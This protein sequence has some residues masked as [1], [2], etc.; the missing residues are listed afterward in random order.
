[1]KPQVVF[2]QVRPKGQRLVAQLGDGFVVPEAD[3]GWQVV[4]RPKRKAFTTWD[5]HAPVTMTIPIL[6]DGFRENRSVEQDINT[7]YGMMRK[8]NQ[9]VDEPPVVRLSGPIPYSRFQ[10]VITSISPGEEIRRKKDGRRVRSFM[11]VTVLEYV[12]ADVATTAKA[13][14]AKAARD[15]K[16][17][18]G[19]KGD[20]G[21]S[22]SGRTYRVK[23]GDT[24]AKIAVRFL[25]SAGEWRKIAKMNNIRDPKRLKVGQVLRIPADDS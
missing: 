15:R 11:E 10:W 20:E 12:P 13:S 17:R 6:F 19:D 8:I 21:R 1:M 16:N 9:R 14:P 22:P 2:K 7:L 18:K 5:G 4:A 25:G 23:S 24:L 3:S